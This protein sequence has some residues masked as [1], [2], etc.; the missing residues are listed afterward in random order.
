MVRIDM[1]E[2]GDGVGGIEGTGCRAVSLARSGG[3]LTERL[4][5]NPYT[6]LLLDSEV[7]GGFEFDELYFLQAFDEGMVDRWTRQESA[8]LSDIVI[9]GF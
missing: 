4:R 8:Y 3:V 1:S 9:M 2:Y 5:E 6:V 7:E